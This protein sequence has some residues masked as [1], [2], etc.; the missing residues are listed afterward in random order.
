[1]EEIRNCEHRKSKIECSI[2]IMQKC[3]LNIEACE[4]IVNEILII[5]ELVHPNLVKILNTYQ[6][7]N[8]IYIIE[9]RFNGEE[10]LSILNSKKTLKINEVY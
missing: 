10:L 9:E 6:D 1:M 3:H 7:E 2:K 4:A 5:K 8:A